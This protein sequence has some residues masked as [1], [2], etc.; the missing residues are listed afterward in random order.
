MSKVSPIIRSMNAGEFSPLMEGRT[1]VDRYPASM[2][3]LYNTIAAPQGPGLCRSGTQYVGDVYDHT[4]RSTL[5]P[6]VFSETDFYQIEFS[7]LRVR[8]FTETGVLTY[9]PVDMTV[10]TTLP[11][12]IDAPTLGADV[13]DEVAFSEFEAEDNM[14]G[15]VAKITAKSGTEYTLDFEPPAPLSIVGTR[16]A[17]RVYH[18]VSPYTSDQIVGVN[19]RQSL[20]VIYLTN[21]SIKTYKLQRT[22]TYSWSFVEVAFSDGPYLDENDTTTTLTMSDTGRA[23]PTMTSNTLPSGTCA[24]STE[25]AGNEAYRAFD[26]PSAN[27]Y[28]Q[29]TTDQTGT[30]QY[31][32]ASAFVC[33][34]YSIHIPVN[35][36]DTS[37]SSKD[38]APS[39]FTFEGYNGSAWVVLD[40]QNNYVLYDNNKSVFFKLANTVAYTAYRINILGCV[41]NGPLKPRIKSLIMRS[42]TVGNI[43]VTASAVTGINNGAGFKTTDVGRLLRVRGSDFF[44]RPMKIMSHSSTTVVTAKLLGEPFPNL[45]A[46]SRWRLGLYSDTTGYAHSSNFH[47]DRLWLGGSISFPDQYAAS[48]TGSYESMSPSSESGEVLATHGITGRLNARRLALIKWLEGNKDGISLGTGAKEYLLRSADGPGKAMLPTTGLRVIDS[49]SRGS[50]DTPPVAVDAQV[51]YVSRGGRTLREH[52]Y[53]YESDGYKS[54]SMSSLASHLGISPFVKQAYAQEPYSIDWLLRADGVVI[55]F[56]YNRDENVVGWHQHDFNGVVESISVV[57][58]SDQL[59]DT[60][61][62]IVRRTIDGQTRRHIEKL[63]KFW[64][65]DMSI[66]DAWYVDAGLRYEGT[67]ASAVYGLLHLEGRTD[68]YGLADGKAI[69]PLTVD[70]GSITLPF[71]ASNI[72]VGIGFESIG[73]TSRLENGAQD[74]T[75]QGKTKRIHNISMALW[76]SFGGEIGVWNENT[77]EVMW[78]PIEYESYDATDVDMPRLVD[79]IVGPLLPEGSYEKNGSVHFRRPKGSPYPLN[80]TAIMPQ[81]VTQDR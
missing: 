76:Q 38:F 9:T 51:L 80:I 21:K 64:D 66:D 50:S 30:L 54:P 62:L 5:I 59:R 74:G 28:W 13:G 78:S 69:G 65:F 24:A 67:P 49:G 19:D 41:R 45:N 44:W 31:T 10:L 56:T 42:A 33:D 63:T 27:T 22:D 6:F 8:F 20:D 48:E 25:N 4:K 34:G 77:Q 29:P 37:Y 52:A 17:A 7:D 70:N 2:R 40:T 3:K 32:P 72:V 46:S 71:E 68:V 14:N 36:S 1:D 79:G 23:T 43:T 47:D 15:T 75:A 35:N 81:M 11:L 26:D 18:I 39:N 53:T 12:K 60:L 73:E 55:G 57:P 61:W 58:S 16:K